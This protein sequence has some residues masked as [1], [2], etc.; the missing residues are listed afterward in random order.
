MSD[1]A[2]DGYVCHGPMT[3]VELPSVYDGACAVLCEECGVWRHRFSPGDPRR[4]KVEALMP[5][6]IDAH[7]TA[8]IAGLE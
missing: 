6:I 7:I 2:N 1:P 8:S 5:T 3:F 4:E